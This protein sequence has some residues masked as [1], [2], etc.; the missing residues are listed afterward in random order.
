MRVEFVSSRPAHI[1][2]NWVKRN[3][4][5]AKRD[6]TNRPVRLFLRQN[7]E[8]ASVHL[9]TTIGYARDYFRRYIFRDRSIGFEYLAIIDGRFLN[10][11]RRVSRISSKESQLHVST[12]HVISSLFSG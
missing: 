12:S 2:I 4:N 1:S 8:K 10:F 6:E 5:S 3:S 9:L 7:F 11:F